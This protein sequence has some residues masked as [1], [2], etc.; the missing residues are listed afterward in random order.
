MDVYLISLDDHDGMVDRVLVSQESWNYL[1]GGPATAAMEADLIAEGHTA[2]EAQQALGYTGS[3]TNERANIVPAVTVNG[4]QC[5]GLN[6]DSVSVRNV[7]AFIA[8][9]GLTLAGEYDGLR[10]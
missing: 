4:E 8:K 5:G 7:M 3:N 6:S 10:F 9:H 1:S 2:A